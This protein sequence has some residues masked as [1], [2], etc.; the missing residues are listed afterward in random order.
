MANIANY[1]PSFHM[2]SRERPYGRMPVIS[3]RPPRAV[4]TKEAANKST[5]NFIYWEAKRRRY[6][7]L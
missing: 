3:E 6:V 2:C 1:I 4:K 7:V 5:D